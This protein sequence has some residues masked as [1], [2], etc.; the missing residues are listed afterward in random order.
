MS[1]VA[2]QPAGRHARRR[3][4]APRRAA[5]RRADARRQAGLHA[6]ER[7]RDVRGRRHG[8]VDGHPAGRQGAGTRRLPVQDPEEQPRGARD[9]HARLL[10]GAVD[11]RRGRPR[12]DDGLR[13]SDRPGLRGRLRGQARRRRRAVEARPV[14]AAAGRLRRLL[15]RQAES[16][17]RGPD[18]SG[19]HPGGEPEPGRGAVRRGAP[20]PRVDGPRLSRQAEAAGPLPPRKAG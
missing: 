18:R 9:R 10:E 5:R 4:G 8:R 20:Q 1:F 11:H 2:R 16:A 14:R 6:E 19:D 12:A 17:R 3:A 15:E 13:R 7:D